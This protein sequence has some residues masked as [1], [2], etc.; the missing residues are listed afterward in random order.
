MEFDISI[1]IVNYN[2]RHFLQQTLESVN[3]SIQKLNVEI[4]VVDNNSVDDSVSMV[5]REFPEVNLIANSDN[6]GFSKANNQA[7]RKSNAKYILLLNPDT[8]LQEDTLVKCYDFM[9]SH[10]EAGAVGAKMIDGSGQFLPESKRGFP[11]PWVSFCKASGLT[12]V[13]KKSKLFNQYHLGFLNENETH[14]IDVLCGAFMFMRNSVLE[15]IGLLDE[16]FFMYGEDI[17]LSYRIKQSGNKVYYLPETQLIHFKGESTKKTSVNYVRVF[18]QAM[19]IFAKKH[20]SGKGAGILILMLN[21]AIFGRA[22]ISLLKRFT[23]KLLPQIL[24]FVTIFIGLVIIKEAWEVTYFHDPNYFNNSIYYSL[25]V[26]SLVYVVSLL[27][28]GVYRRNYKLGQVLRAIFSALIILLAIYGLLEPELRFSRAVLVLSSIWAFIAAIAIRG[29]LRFAKHQDFR[30]GQDV[31]KRIF[32]I[33]EKE[34]IENVLILLNQSFSNHTIVGKIA[35]IEEYDRSYFDGT[36][37]KIQQLA[38]LEKANEFIFCMKDLEWQTVMELMNSMGSQ[39][40][41]KMV[42]DD[43]LSILGSK[44]KNT[45]GELYSVQFEYNL[46]RWQDLIKKRFLDIIIALVFLLLFPFTIWIQNQLT[47]LN[48][49]FN[50]IYYFQNVISLLIGKKTLVGYNK[51]DIKLEE[52]PVLKEGLL[53]V[54]QHKNF[55]DS[56]IHRANVIYAKDYNI[57]KDI[58]LVFSNKRKSNA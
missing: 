24:D 18:Y 13:F 23:E 8:V 2:V 58:E 31:A 33:G 39:I 51:K 42:G 3:R 46:S 27:F 41:Y 4:W 32:I 43:K 19:I 57:W 7:I 40:E 56:F 38:S 30:I 14:E 21:I 1:V 29:L 11:T 15:E 34:E 22:F 25:A 10:T 28:Y 12:K 6:P 48:G 50:I 49:R 35:P 53:E 20:F 54:A 55:D 26:Y 16:A 44:S 47:S 5:Q 37:S 9:E 36:L 52:L 17:D 45:S